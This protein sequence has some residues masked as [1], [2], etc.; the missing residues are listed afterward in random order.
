MATVILIVFLVALALLGG[1]WLKKERVNQKNELLR[2]GRIAEG[3][4]DEAVL[5]PKKPKRK[6]R[7]APA[8]SWFDAKYVPPE[9]PDKAMMAGWVKR[10]AIAV[11]SALPAVQAYRLARAEHKRLQE[12]A[13]S[14]EQHSSCLYLLNTA[15]AV[16]N[17]GLIEE[18]MAAK[19]ETGQKAHDS[20]RNLRRQF[21]ATRDLVL[22]VRSCLSQVEGWELY[23][24]PESF[25]DLVEIVTLLGGEILREFDLDNEPD[26]AEPKERSKRRHNW[27]TPEA[28]PVKDET[29]VEQ[30]R[31]A[32]VRAL[33]M[34]P[35]LIALVDSAFDRCKHLEQIGASISLAKPE[36]PV[37]IEIAA[38]IKQANDA[39][40]LL[41][42]AQVAVYERAQA[43]SQK[44]AVFDD[45]LG[46][47]KARA[48]L[49]S[50]ADIPDSHRAVHDAIML[51]LKQL[52]KY[53]E[54]L[55]PRLAA[56]YKVS[57]PYKVETQETQAMQDAAASLRNAVRKVYFA[58]AQAQSAKASA[59]KLQAE[60]PRL[61]EVN[62]PTL[63]QS[64][65][66]AFVN[67]FAR[68]EEIQGRNKQ[69]TE[70]HGQRCKQLQA[71]AAEREKLARAAVLELKELGNDLD[72]RFSVASADYD[73]SRKVAA[74]VCRAF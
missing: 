43:M 21:K 48:Q 13:H 31:I 11:D 38:S 56:L 6:K 72:Q 26:A 9:V 63:S 69:K 2:Q 15:N 54:L 44:R 74:L 3:K 5:T 41:Q 10:A 29:I 16:Y 1:W 35:E 58:V 42:E 23:K 71:Q 19:Y 22:D 50:S 45:A 34:L 30:T 65:A 32:F 47:A 4:F 53:F 57:R 67:A 17:F 8:S 46:V 7:K 14:A 37:D 36:K 24:A 20:A 25:H 73:V 18:A 28:E 49:M 62:A 40:M 55:D 60:K 66:Q 33:E 12:E 64:S 68:M 52:A 61:A 27:G 51:T 59:A 39:A 70:E